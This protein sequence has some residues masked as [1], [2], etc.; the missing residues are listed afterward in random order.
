VP[1]RGKK[2]RSDPE[3]CR[4]S[5][6][7]APVNVPQVASAS[8]PA[9][10]D[11]PSMPTPDSAQDDRPELTVTADPLPPRRTLIH[12]AIDRLSA[13]TGRRYLDKATA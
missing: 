5:V 3:V 11:N 1:W 12:A 13:R 10:A 7:V 6:A 4:L 9:V 8:L 2:P